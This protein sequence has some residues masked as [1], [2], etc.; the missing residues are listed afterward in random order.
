MFP[1]L[2]EGWEEEGAF[3]EPLVEGFVA[4]VGGSQCE[5]AE[6]GDSGPCEDG[7]AVYGGACGAG[8]DDE[9]EEG[10][11]AVLTEEDGETAGAGGAVALDVSQVAEEHVEHEEGPAPARGHEE[12]WA[13]GEALEEDGRGEDGR[14]DDQWSEEGFEDGDIFQTPAEEG[15]GVAEGEGQGEGGEEEEAG[16][17]DAEGPEKEDGD[18]EPGEEPAPGA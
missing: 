7:P 8:G 18:A 12:G 6:G 9:P 10:L 13:D 11:G 1:N 17:A 16:I 15:E 4:A 14:E 2:N 3:C 5:R